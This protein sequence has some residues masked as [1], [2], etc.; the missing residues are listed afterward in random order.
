LATFA[1]TGAK[2]GDRFADIH[3]ALAVKAL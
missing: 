1:A 2:L 3:A